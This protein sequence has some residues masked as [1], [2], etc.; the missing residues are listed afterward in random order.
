MSNLRIVDSNI[1]LVITF[2]RTANR[3][4][5]IDTPTTPS[6]VFDYLRGYAT[7]LLYSPVLFVRYIRLIRNHDFS[8]Q[9]QL[10][11][12]R[13]DPDWLRNFVLD[14]SRQE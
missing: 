7:I 4:F 6:T 9:H 8:N 1:A 14:H 13:D 10:V 2:I 3:T 5:G 11:D 12:I